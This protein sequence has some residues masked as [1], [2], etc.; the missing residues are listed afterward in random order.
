[1]SPSWP[2]AYSREAQRAAC[3]SR[4]A[5]DIGHTFAPPAVGAASGMPTRAVSEPAHALAAS[6][7][8][9]LRRPSPLATRGMA[10]ARLGGRPTRCSVITGTHGD[11]PR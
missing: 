4:P 3:L 5:A 2:G 9:Q 8:L 1:M 11:Q 10:D 7:Y 6:A